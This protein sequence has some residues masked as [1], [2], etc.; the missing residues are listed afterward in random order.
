[1]GRG[2]GEGYEDEVR[3]TY[4]LPH[5]HRVLLILL[6]QLLAEC[7]KLTQRLYSQALCQIELHTTSK[8]RL[9]V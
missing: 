1:M 2:W 6:L 9:L 7:N 8:D 3:I 5:F 4:L